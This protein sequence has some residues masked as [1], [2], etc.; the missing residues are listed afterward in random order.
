MGMSQIF[1]N[2]LILRR[3]GVSVLA[4]GT[5]LIACTTEETGDDF[6]NLTTDGGITVDSSVVV[7]EPDASSTDARTSD[8]NVDGSTSTCSDGS[9]IVAEFASCPGTPPS[10]P[11]S[12]SSA[13]ATATRGD[14]VSL[15]TAAT[16]E[17]TAPCF[18]VHVCVPTDAPKMMFSDSPESPASSGVLY[19]DT[20]GPGRVRI[21]VYHTNGENDGNARKFPIVVLNQG[22][23]TAH[24]TIIQ[25]GIAGPSTDYVAVG[26][27][28]IG[29]WF[30]STAGSPI[31]LD[32][33]TRVLLDSDL[34]AVHAAHDELVHAIYDVMLDAPVKISVVSVLSTDD[35]A[36]LTASLSLLAADA[37]HQRATFDGADRIIESE[38]N[39]PGDGIRKISLGGNDDVDTNLTG[40]DAVDG[41]T[42]SLGGNYGV[43]YTLL[44]GVGAHESFTLVP[45]GGAWGGAGDSSAGE[46][47]ASGAVAFPS[48]SD[49]ANAD[50]SAVAAGRFASAANVRMHLISAG[51]SS[52][53]VHVAVVPLP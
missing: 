2:R 9:P 13:L 22:T 40:H 42:A 52:L 25:K 21:Y 23:T 48:A 32:T 33:G 37:D 45:R 27:A 49:S 14:I 51:G 20:V 26:K 5:A 53:P 44:I 7:V 34:D 8:A 11:T 39:V 41:T 4:I 31:E 50:G 46:D 16:P 17:S 18:P 47:S 38:G 29:R 28:A 15:D 3:F 30:A 12:L 35:A 19:A 1:M 10:V 43:L 6:P 36:S 24:A